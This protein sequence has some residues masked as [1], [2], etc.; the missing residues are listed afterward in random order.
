MVMWVWAWACP[1]TAMVPNHHPW[2]LTATHQ[3][4]PPMVPNWAP[5]LDLTL[6]LPPPPP[7]TPG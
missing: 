7:L 3:R 5:G 4:P 6:T 1:S 2:T